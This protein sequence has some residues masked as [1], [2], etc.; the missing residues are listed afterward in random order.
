MNCGAVE[1]SFCLRQ[2]YV[3]PLNG[4]DIAGVHNLVRTKM[5]FSLLNE[6]LVCDYA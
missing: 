6:N 1:K 4:G 3:S 2:F 5:Q